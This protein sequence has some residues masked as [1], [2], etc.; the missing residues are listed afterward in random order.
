MPRL[1]FLLAP[2]LLGVQWGGIAPGHSPQVKSVF[3]IMLEIYSNQLVEK[4]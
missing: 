2:P 3:K 1:L 4:S